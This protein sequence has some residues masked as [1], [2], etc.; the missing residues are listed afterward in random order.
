MLAPSS[1]SSVTSTVGSIIQNGTTRREMIQ[2]LLPQTGSESQ[3]DQLG[4]PRS[5]DCPALETLIAKAKAVW[6]GQ[7]A[8]AWRGAM[9]EASVPE[10]TAAGS[11]TARRF[12]DR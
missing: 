7:V 6:V 3:H 9:W 8:T 2:G 11:W 12:A 4:D 10:T 1:L 5:I